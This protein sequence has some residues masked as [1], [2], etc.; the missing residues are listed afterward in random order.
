M[1]PSA[2]SRRHSTPGLSIT[3]VLITAWVVTGCTP[4]ATQ[5][6]RPPE[7]PR[8]APAAPE[9]VPAG[10]LRGRTGA[11]LIVP[12]AASRVE[13]GRLPAGETAG[14]PTHRLGPAAA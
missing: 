5:Q 14:R 4:R 7:A 11:Y 12:D 13:E 6:S 2:L 9:R 3:S 1:V 8:V 10:S